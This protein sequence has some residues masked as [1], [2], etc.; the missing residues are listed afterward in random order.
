MTPALK[1][2]NAQDLASAGVSLHRLDLAVDDLAEVVTDTE[3]I[4][5][6]A[7]QP[8][9]SAT[10]AFPTY[11]RNNITAT[12][13]LLEA[14]RSSQSLK[15]LINAS[16][17]SVYG[18]HATESEDAPP[19]PTSYYGV[20][21]LAAEQLVLAYSR[22]LSSRVVPFDCSPCTA[23]G[24]APKSSI[25]CSSAASSRTGSSPCSRV[26]RSIRD[27]SPSWGT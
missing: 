20:T 24:N 19:K 15:C 7:A 21:K 26:A 17:S 6:L 25:P 12:H 10:T 2:L 22:L 14:A 18:D 3:I 11:A 1:E 13:R 4:Y 27:P 16:T 23:R 5:H 9:L 8:G